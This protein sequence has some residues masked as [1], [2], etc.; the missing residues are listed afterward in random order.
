MSPAVWQ[1]YQ[2]WILPRTSR[3]N[4]A[5]RIVETTEWKRT[6]E[7]RAAPKP[8][9]FC[10]STGS[11]YI[12]GRVHVHET[13]PRCTAS[14]PIPGV[15]RRG[16]LAVRACWYDRERDRILHGK[17]RDNASELCANGSSR[18]RFP[19]CSGDDWVFFG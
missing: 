7:S 5:F 4:A 16:S 17:G 1:T 9:R 19:L 6:Q 15:Y 2:G 11:R 10:N 8:Q 12:L 14:V 13:Q 3:A 18:A